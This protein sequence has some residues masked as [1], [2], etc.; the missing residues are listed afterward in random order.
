[1]WA[2]HDGPDGWGWI[3]MTLMMAFFWLPLLLA[4]VWVV[5]QWTPAGGPPPRS[6]GEP[7]A[8]EI[9]RRAYARGELGRERFIE[10][11]AD[12]D[13]KGGGTEPDRPPA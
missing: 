11:I 9:A 5:R 1:M 12:L 10:I 7:D 3:W 13:G 4:L 2:W 6:P 8:K